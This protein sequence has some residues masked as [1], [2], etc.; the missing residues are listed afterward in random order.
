MRHI[1]FLSGASLIAVLATAAPAAAQVYIRAPFVRV[2]VGGPGVH[3]R[4]PF[5]NLYVPS[6][7][8]V[9]VMPHAEMPQ[10]DPAPTFEAPAPEAVPTEAIPEPKKTPRPQPKP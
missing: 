4:A 2:Q 8:R 10:A 1:N 3:V 5:V 6:T 7:P 9:H